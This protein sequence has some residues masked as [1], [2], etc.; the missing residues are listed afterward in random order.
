MPLHFVG[1]YATTVELSAFGKL[2]RVGWVGVDLFFVLSGFLI[3]GILLE[4]RGTP[5]Y[6]RAFYWRRVLRILPA[7]SLLMAAM[8]AVVLFLPAFDPE[9]AARFRRWQAAY[10][11]FSTSL[12]APWVGG[13]G[14]FPF[15]SGFLWSLGVEEN[16]YLVW[17][18]VVARTRGKA[19]V[20]LLTGICVTAL[21]TR[22]LFLATGDA[23]YAAY[24]FTPCRLDALAAGGLLA[25][26]WR[27]E[28]SRARVARVVQPLANASAWVWLAVAAGVYAVLRALD[29]NAF[30]HSIPA[31][32][33]G[34]TFTAAM[35]VLLIGCA[36]AANREAPLGRF[37]NWRPLRSLGRYAYALYLFHV[38][39]A[40]AVKMTGVTIPRLA[41][42][43]HSLF[44]A[45]VIF[46]AIA[47]GVCY[48]AAALSWRMLEQ[49][50]LSF[51]D[52]VPYRS[53][54]VRASAY[55][56]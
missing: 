20:W 56:E 42:A 52:A 21:L 18:L 55:G 47:G 32:A 16:Y 31:R 2:T 12:F 33:I 22:L 7:F 17:P 13:I 26:A 11:T 40:A 38:M 10:W 25:F 43:T 41:A 27:R 39:V 54:G 51:R 23:T 29:P 9:G 36:L 34:F 45:E 48:V 46:T 49:P 24:T 50:A 37:C 8:W 35:A 28:E 5:G 1:Q 44:A 6:Y 53:A 3:T 14:A 15:G 4:Q 19:L 30:P